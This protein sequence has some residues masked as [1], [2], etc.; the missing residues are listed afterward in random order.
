MPQGFAGIGGR[1]AVATAVAQT[2]DSGIVR[3]HDVS[4]AYARP[5][6]SIQRPPRQTMSR[7]RDVPGGDAHGGLGVGAGEVERAGR[8]GPQR[9]ERQHVRLPEPDGIRRVERPACRAGW[10]GTPGLMPTRTRRAPVVER[11]RARDPPV[12][13]G[14]DVRGPHA[15]AVAVGVRAQ[16][17]SRRPPTRSGSPCM[18][19]RVA[20]I[21]RAL[22][23]SPRKTLPG[24]EQV[25][26]DRVGP[27]VRHRQ[28]P[29][30]TMIARTTS[31]ST[32]V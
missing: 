20:A 9:R 5:H 18:T 27:D 22:R 4:R 25:R 24:A 19:P 21:D 1:H 26:L 16:V 8:R 7:T 28:R 10:P 13:A 11:P 15:V 23:N 31:I 32:R 30:I 14:R 2:N 6:R 3:A 17:A 12:D 29:R